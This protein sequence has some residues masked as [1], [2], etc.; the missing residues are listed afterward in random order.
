MDGGA[1]EEA[2]LAVFGDVA[3]DETW[4]GGGGDEEG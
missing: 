4:G 3:A 1:A 2:E